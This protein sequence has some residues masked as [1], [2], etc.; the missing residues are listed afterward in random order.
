[1]NIDK[2]TERFFF[3]AVTVAYFAVFPIILSFYIKSILFIY[4]VTAILYI[5]IFFR[6]RDDIWKKF[7]SFVSSKKKTN[8]D[9]EK[10]REQIL[11]SQAETII[12]MT[13]EERKEKKVRS[14]Q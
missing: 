8:P 7:M 4:I 10:I 9:K 11:K 6:Y 5:P 12:K 2:I 13:S 3:V 1:M 14:D